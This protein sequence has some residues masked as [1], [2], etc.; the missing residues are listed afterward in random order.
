MVQHRRAYH[1]WRIADPPGWIGWTT[2][3]A[4]CFAADDSFGVAGRNVALANRMAWVYSG[5]DVGLV[6]SSN[7]A[8]AKVDVRS[9][10][11]ARLC[12]QGVDRA[13]NDSIFHYSNTPN[14]ARDLLSIV[15]AWDEWRAEA[16]VTAKP[17]SHAE[18]SEPAHG[19]GTNPDSNLKPK[20]TKGKLVYIGY[21][22]GT[23]LGATFAAMFPDKVGRVVLD[24]VVDADHYGTP[25]TA[26]LSLA[27]D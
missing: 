6:N 20:S 23:L 7:V 24:G 21:S 22:Y 18:V 13:G 15:H 12:K 14:V 4:D 26:L 11:V 3:K 8:L 10:A 17:G 1:G 25:A 19:D 2:P 16:A 27:L 5:H 9:R